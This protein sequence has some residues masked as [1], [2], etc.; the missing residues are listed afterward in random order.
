MG[1]ASVNNSHTKPNGNASRKSSG[2]LK[3]LQIQERRDKAISLHLLGKSQREIS[4][5]LGV[6]VGVINKDINT[7]LQDAAK[8][9]FD[10]K[11]MLVKLDWKYQQLERELLAGLELAESPEARHDAA[12]KV[13]PKLLELYKNYSRTFGVNMPQRVNVDMSGEATIT[14]KV[15]SAEGGDGNV[16]RVGGGGGALIEG[17]TVSSG[18][19]NQ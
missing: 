14:L 9:H 12:L 8:E 4:E 10:T 18:E 3:K 15:E 16:V 7:R 6:S 19:D 13:A 11:A 1:G 17:E 5:E 2:S